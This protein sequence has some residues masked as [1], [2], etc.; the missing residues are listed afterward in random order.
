MPPRGKFAP[1][2]MS[3]AWFLLLNCRRMAMPTLGKACSHLLNLTTLLLGSLLSLGFENTG[4]FRIV[5]IPYAE[6]KK[7]PRYYGKGETHKK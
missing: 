2:G 6:Q 1:L 5:I 4:Y 3:L 7:V